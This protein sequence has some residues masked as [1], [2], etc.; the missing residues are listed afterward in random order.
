MQE[1][2]I[3]TPEQENCAELSYRN[4]GRLVRLWFVTRFTAK[5][6]PRQTLSVWKPQLTSSE[7][8]HGKQDS[9]LVFVWKYWN[10]YVGKLACDSSRKKGSLSP[11]D[12]MSKF[13]ARHRRYDVK[14]SSFEGPSAIPRSIRSWTR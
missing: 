11:Q 3:K 4:K 13:L 7:V 5:F 8:S 1:N 2:Q 6:R 14:S 12:M 9:V 10:T